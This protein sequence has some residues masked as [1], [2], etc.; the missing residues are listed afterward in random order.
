MYVVM[1]LCY[2]VYKWFCQLPSCL[3]ICKMNLSSV[4]IKLK[5]VFLFVLYKS[6]PVGLPSNKIYQVSENVYCF[7]PCSFCYNTNICSEFL[8]RLKILIA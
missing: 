5:V 7:L 3:F 8:A 2:V 6:E 4:K 1:E